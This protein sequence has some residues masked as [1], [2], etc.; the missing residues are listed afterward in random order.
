[1]RL[2][3]PRHL[4]Q[5]RNQ[6]RD[7]LPIV[8]DIQ[9]AGSHTRRAWNDLKPPR[10]PKIPQTGLDG[11]RRHGKLISQRRQHHQH[12]SGVLRLLIVEAG[13]G[14]VLD[15]LVAMPPA[16]GIVADCATKVQTRLIK[17]RAGVP[18]AS[19][20]GVR[21]RQVRADRGTAFSEDPRLL[22]A[23]ALPGGTQ[24]F[25]VIQVYGHHQGRI[26]VQHVDGVQPAPQAHLQDQN[27]Q[28]ELSKNIQGRQGAKLE[29]GQGNIPP[30][31]VDPVEGAAELLIRRLLAVHA[32]PFVVV[33]QVGRCIGPHPVSGLS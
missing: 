13:L 24:P 11:L 21:S 7:G 26:G 16:P 1:M 22:P 8:R 5:V 9:D 10:Q 30:R 17:P 27:I 4:F 15:K 2:S 20:Y 25:L 6:G 3:R 33:H 12:A 32:N 14:Q 18:G 23:Y 28:L 19:R 31:P 29:I